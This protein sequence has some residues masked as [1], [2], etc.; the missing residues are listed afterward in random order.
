MKLA[1]TAALVTGAGQGIGQAIALQ[2]AAEGA[3]IALNVRADDERARAVRDEIVAL[4]RR[5]TI[6]PADVS[7]VAGTRAMVQQAGAD[8]PQLCILVNNAGVERHAPL[9]EVSED[10]YDLVL[11]VNL[12]GPFFLIQHFARWLRAAGR[13][14]RIVNISSVHEELPFPNFAPYCAS[15]GGLKMLMRD[16]A[17][18]LA[19]FGITVN[20]VAPGAIRTPI[21]DA[22]LANEAQLKAL[23]AQIPL[24][25]LG[26]PPDVAKLVAFLA[27]EDARYITGTTSVVDGGLLWNYTEQ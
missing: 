6:Y 15:K 11:D 12:K 8:F 24:G 18:E 19:P 25:R 4:G 3:D 22:L 13:P 23:T 2:L 21:N 16:A 5:C 10:D 1:N 7:R 9:L 14:G 27:S 20:N 26:T 17:V